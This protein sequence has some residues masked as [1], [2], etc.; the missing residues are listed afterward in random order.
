MLYYRAR[1]Y[2]YWWKILCTVPRVGY[3]YL[4]GVPSGWCSCEYP[5]LNSCS[6]QIVG[7]LYF[8]QKKIPTKLSTP[9]GGGVSTLESL[10]N[11]SHNVDLR[12]LCYLYFFKSFNMNLGDNFLAPITGISNKPPIYCRIMI[13][14]GGDPGILV[15]W[16]SSGP[17]WSPWGSSVRG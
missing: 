15:I 8:P 4:E 5:G 11:G 10:T 2:K 16:K 1:I 7:A 14:S 12:S 17:W 3:Q 9:K 13:C 6:Y